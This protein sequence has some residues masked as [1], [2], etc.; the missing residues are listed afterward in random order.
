M[1]AKDLIL[2]YLNGPKGEI[3]MSFGY[4]L[5]CFFIPPLAVYLKTGET[6][7]TLINLVLTVAGFWL[8]GMI[9]AFVVVNRAFKS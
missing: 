6:K 8:V 4:M 2:N 3:Q 1:L 5:L 9:H 7:D